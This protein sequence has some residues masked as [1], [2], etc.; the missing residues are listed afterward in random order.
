MLLYVVWYHTTVIIQVY[1]KLKGNC[2]KIRETRLDTV[3][4]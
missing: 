2:R 1:E 4:R 3:S